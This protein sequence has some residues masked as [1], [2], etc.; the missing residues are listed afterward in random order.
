MD[1]KQ[2]KREIQFKKLLALFEKS[3]EF[4]ED[5][6]IV[7]FPKLGYMSIIG[8]YLPGKESDAVISKL[9]FHRYFSTPL[10]MADS[11][12]EN[13][14]WQW[15]VQNH[16][17]VCTDDYVSITEMDAELSKEKYPEYFQMLKDYS[18]EI[19]RILKDTY[20]V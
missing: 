14:R 8:K 13:L 17:P 7:E 11:L 4:S 16:S 5:Y 6:H 10:E 19:S 20:N 2:D 1:D 18:F 3:L 15:Y 9:L 12:M